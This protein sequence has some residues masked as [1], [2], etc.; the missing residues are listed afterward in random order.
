MNPPRARAARRLPA[1]WEPQDAVLLTWPHDESDWAPT[2]HEVEPVFVAIA[3][4]VCAHEK[5]L[6]VLRDA[7][8]RAHVESLLQAAGVDL[9]R[10]RVVIAPS[11]DTWA[12]DHGPITV[13]EGGEPRLLDFVFNGW[14]GKFEAAL[15]DAITARL[16]EAG[17]FGAATRERLDFVLEGGSLESDGAGTLITTQE[18]QHHAG[19]N[20]AL[21]TAAI[22]EQLMQSFGLERV[23]WLHHGQLEGDDTDGHIDTLVRL[24]DTNT[25]AYQHCDDVA[26]PH[27]AELAAMET[28]VKALR[29]TAGEPYR[30]MPLPWPSPKRHADGRRMPATYANFLILNGAVLVPTY[31]DANDALAL[32]RLRGAFPGREVI[33]I[34]CLPLIA[35]GGSLHCVTMQLPAG[36]LAP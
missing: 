9:S 26:D 16:Q 31:R 24:C 27:F 14:G 29:T 12:R 7:E 13:L 18:C 22:E 2:L 21:G 35:Q 36:T 34:D 6:L 28:E 1:E 20:P 8:H 5:L 11:N 3:A 32:E 10:V 33:G 30:L 15:D 23:L 17:V 19:R 4:A 25:L